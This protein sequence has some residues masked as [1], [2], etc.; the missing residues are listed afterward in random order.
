MVT[1]TFYFSLVTLVIGVIGG[2]YLFIHWLRHRKHKFSLLWAIGLFLLYWFQ[3]PFILANA[4]VRFTVTNFNLFYSITLPLVFLGTILIYLGILSVSPFKNQKR[5]NLYLFLWFVLSALV[6]AYYFIFQVGYSTRLFQFGP[7]L[8]FF[9]PLYLLILSALWRWYRRQDFSKTKSTSIGL[10]AITLSILLK[11]GGSLIAISRM[12]AYP[13]EFWFIALTDFDTL[14]FLEA[15]NTLLLLTG[16]FLVHKN[17]CRVL[18][19]YS[20][21][22]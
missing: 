3:V 9:L 13:P 12:L 4:G 7:T 11:I 14:F 20:K 18:D 16:F 17:C 22:M 21:S 5:V 19:G 2:L 6:F 10:I 1:T 8:V 15:L